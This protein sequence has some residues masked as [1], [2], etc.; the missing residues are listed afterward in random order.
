MIAPRYPWAAGED[1]RAAL[2]DVLAK[3]D[4]GRPIKRS[5]G[6]NIK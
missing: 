5:I 1:L 2:D 3:R 4:I 6:C